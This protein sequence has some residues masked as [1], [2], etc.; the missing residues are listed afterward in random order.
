MKTGPACYWHSQKVFIS[1]HN[2][3][4]ELWYYTSLKFIVMRH[5]MLDVYVLQPFNTFTDTQDLISYNATAEF[6]LK[7]L[8]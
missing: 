5:C 8:Y 4:N 6:P 2:V 7:Y 3:L 1:F